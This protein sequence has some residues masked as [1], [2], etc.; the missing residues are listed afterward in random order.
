MRIALKLLGAYRDDLSTVYTKHNTPTDLQ[1]VRG[2]RGVRRLIAVR[3]QK[4]LTRLQLTA[5]QLG[6]T[7]PVPG[8]L[9]ISQ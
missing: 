9:L 6:I 5:T 3:F 2:H 7:P 1:Q 8:E 4:P